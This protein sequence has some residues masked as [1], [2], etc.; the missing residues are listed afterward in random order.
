MRVLGIDGT[1]KGWVAVVL[2][3]GRFAGAHLYHA[4]DELVAA[5]EDAQVL[6]TDI[7]I[8][9]LD[10]GAREAD[11]CARA[12]VGALRSS[13]FAM[14]PRAVV[15]Q[16]EWGEA[17]RLAR[18]LTGNGISKQSFALFRRVLEVDAFL[19]DERLFEVHPEVCFALLAGAPLKASKKTWEGAGGRRAPLAGVGVVLPEALGPAGQA[20]VD[21]VLDAAVAAWSAGRIARGE[22][23]CFPPASRQRDRGGRVVAIWG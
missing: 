3:D 18:Q 5:H 4:F 16:V 23:V 21:D 22:A 20:A 12:A 19:E 10:E 14:P 13:V 7:P 17:L 9:L 15:E 1:K 2:E 8:G 6:A 11:S